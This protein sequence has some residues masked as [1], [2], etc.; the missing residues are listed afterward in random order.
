ML[1]PGEL[2]HLMIMTGL[3]VLVIGLFTFLSIAAW[4]K[5]RKREREAFYRSELRKTLIEKWGGGSPEELVN[6]LRDDAKN[7]E[8]RQLLDVSGEGK[9]NG[10]RRRRDGLLLAGLITTA[11][12]VGMLVFLRTLP[13]RDAVSNIGIIPL[14]VG[15]AILIHSFIV[16]R[17]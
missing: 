3:A 16:S 13:T 6:L 1:L 7:A 8:L 14:I 17:H 15:V 4:A 11:I 2:Y 9:Q 10:A 12:G 5:A